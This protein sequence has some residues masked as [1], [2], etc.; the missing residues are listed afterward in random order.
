MAIYFATAH[1]K[2]ISSW[3]LSRDL[4]IT[5]KTAWFMMHRIREIF[6]PSK[7]KLSGIVEVDETYIGG[8]YKN[9]HTYS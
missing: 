2:G 3:Q 5:Q 7:R 6:K 9:M 4:G 1:K 8:K